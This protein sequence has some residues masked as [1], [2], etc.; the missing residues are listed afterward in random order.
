MYSLPANTPATNKR[1]NTTGDPPAAG[2]RNGACFL[3]LEA[4]W[5]HH[6]PLEK[7]SPPSSRSFH[8]LN[9]P[10]WI[11]SCFMGSRWP[12]ADS[13]GNTPWP[14]DSGQGNLPS[15][16]TWLL[17]ALT[18]CVGQNEQRTRLVTCGR[19]KNARSKRSV[20]PIHA[21]PGL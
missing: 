19:R 1:R 12:I 8:R 4:Q 10:G 20:V 5:Q 11:S 6:A 9:P 16:L 13:P 15:P 7:C 14:A 2:S 18:G 21:T 17:V 3:P